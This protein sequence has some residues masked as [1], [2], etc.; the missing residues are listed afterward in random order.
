MKHSLIRKF[1]LMAAWIAACFLASPPLP[2]NSQEV[3]KVDGKLLGKARNGDFKKSEDASGIAC[4]RSSGFPRLC[5]APMTKRKAPR[6][7]Y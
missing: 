2:A 1:A 6:S 3:W 4:D 7:S 5:L